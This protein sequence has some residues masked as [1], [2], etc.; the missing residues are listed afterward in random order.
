M[1]IGLP[2]ARRSSQSHARGSS[3]NNPEEKIDETNAEVQQSALDDDSDDDSDSVRSVVSLAS[4]ESQ[5][6]R[7]LLPAV[8]PS[9]KAVEFVTL[10]GHFAEVIYDLQ[11]IGQA[12]FLYGTETVP[13]GCY[14]WRMVHEKHNNS[15]PTKPEA[16]FLDYPI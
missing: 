15:P 8:S 14:L 12:D 6:R 10:Q 2:K 3:S 1:E 11:F 7:R 5:R 13:P 9:K 4:T 16:R